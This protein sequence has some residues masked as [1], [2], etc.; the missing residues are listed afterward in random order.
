MILVSG[1]SM[2]VEDNS[3]VTFLR[4]NY[5]YAIDNLSVPAVSNSY[6]ANSIVLYGELYPETLKSCSIIFNITGF[7]RFDVLVDR[8]NPR[9]SKYM[10]WEKLFGVGVI[11]SASQGARKIFSG[12]PATT[13]I[14]EEALLSGLAMENTLE[15]IKLINFLENNNCNWRFIM[16]NDYISKPPNELFKNFITRHIDKNIS[17]GDTRGLYEWGVQNNMLH[18]DQYHLSVKGN[19]IIS[20]IIYEAIK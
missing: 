6:I 7:D 16:M 3:W 4:K 14:Q 2:S 8:E 15:V 1:C 20:S 17:F 12:H 19:E 9:K 11:S 5:H 13:K 18:A 10:P